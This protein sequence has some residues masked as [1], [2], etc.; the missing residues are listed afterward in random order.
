MAQNDSEIRIVDVV[1][2]SNARGYR[3]SMFAGFAL[4]PE[5]EAPS[6]GFKRIEFDR[7][8]FRK[9]TTLRAP[10]AAFKRITSGHRGEPVKLQQ[11]ALIAETPVEHQE[12]GMKQPGLNIQARKV[13]VVQ[14]VIAL[15]LECAQADAARNA[16]MYAATNKIAYLGG[17]RWSD[18]AS[19]PLQDVT[20][21][22][23]QIRKLTGRIANTF[24]VSAA[25]VAKLRLHP[26]ILERFKHTNASSIT[27]EM[28]ASYFSV[29]N[30][31][32][33]GGVFDDD[34][35]TH[36]I[37]G[38]DAVLAFVP[39]G[40]VQDAEVP[41]YGYTYRLASYPMVGA[42]RFNEDFDTW[43]NKVKDEWSPE[44]VG[45]DAGFLFQNCIN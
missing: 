39:D 4:F 7:A 34:L 14:D 8:A 20:D 33:A 38:K 1:L 9:H 31:V 18:D 29:K 12:E 23:E 16:A 44:A 42:V 10:G 36:D 2:T 6:R 22:C 26:K 21:A 25:V 24:V 41:A 40:Q 15:S 5:V 13:T 37:W 11:H 28:L 19:D 32:V 27:D 17:S 3:N 43:D 45:P 35:G 30:F